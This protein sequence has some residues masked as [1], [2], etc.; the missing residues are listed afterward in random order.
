MHIRWLN[1]K[2]FE[3]FE[4][5]AFSLFLSNW[6]QTC[7]VDHSYKMVWNFYLPYPKL[8][9]HQYCSIKWFFRNFRSSPYHTCSA[10]LGVSWQFNEIQLN[11]WN[12]AI[13]LWNCWNLVSAHPTWPAFDEKWNGTNFKIIWSSS[14]TKQM[15]FMD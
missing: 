8:M 10:N 4:L 13:L 14:F 1:A 12:I 5:F 6:G 15:I 7:S 3:F 11:A 9:H 2:S